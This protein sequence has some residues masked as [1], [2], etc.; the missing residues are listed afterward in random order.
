MRRPSHDDRP[1]CDLLSCQQRCGRVQVQLVLGAGMYAIYCPH[2]WIRTLNYPRPG[3]DSI[4]RT[5]F[6]RFEVFLRFV[7]SSA[8]VQSALRRAT[9]EKPALD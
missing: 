2:G 7:H 6:D 8:Y 4:E 5:D 1:A 9:S 3:D